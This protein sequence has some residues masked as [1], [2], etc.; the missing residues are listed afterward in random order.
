MISVEMLLW[1]FLMYFSAVLITRLTKEPPFG[2]II[3]EETDVS[4]TGSNCQQ[5]QLHRQ[6]NG[7]KTPLKY[8]IT[9]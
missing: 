5:I 4:T 2:P 7:V 9:S 3:L 8:I 6:T 1:K